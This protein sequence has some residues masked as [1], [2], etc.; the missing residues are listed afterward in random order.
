MREKQKVARHSPPYDLVYK[1]EFLT[2]TEARKRENY[3]KRRKSRKFIEGLFLV[4][5]RGVA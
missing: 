2:S 1:E 5:N 3:I 4:R